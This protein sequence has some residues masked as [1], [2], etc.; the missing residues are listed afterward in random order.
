M[1]LY[2]MFA[3]K[4]VYADHDFTFGVGLGSLYSGVG[5]HSTSKCTIN[6]TR[7]YIRVNII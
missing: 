1:I 3:G 2:L 5:P 7:G 6:E 4:S